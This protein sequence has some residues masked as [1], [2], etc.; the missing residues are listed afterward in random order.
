MHKTIPRRSRRI[1]VILKVIGLA[2]ATS[3]L[4]FS[5]VAVMDEIVCKVNGEIVTRS[6]MEKSRQELETHLRVEQGLRGEKLDE[7]IKVQFPDL[8]RNRIDSV[9]LV[10][11]AKELDI[12]VDTELD[13]QIAEMQRKSKIADPEKFQAAI[14]EQMGVSYE[15]FRGDL[16]NQM[17]RE[18]VLG[19]EVG[20]K[21]QFKREELEAYYNAHRDEFQKEERVIL[22]HIFISSA[23]LDAA[24]QAAWG[25]RRSRTLNPG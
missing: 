9:L 4:L 23:G 11:R 18:R 17:L 6:E 7:A 16:K 20:R 22:S 5:E 15:D 2:L 3:A 19:E 10:Q 25:F 24:G 13:K 8:L 14:R 1:F 21:I 12:E